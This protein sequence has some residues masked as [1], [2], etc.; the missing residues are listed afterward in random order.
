MAA[1]WPFA[2]CTQALEA[3]HI[4]HGHEMKEIRQQSRTIPWEEPLIWLLLSTHELVLSFFSIFYVDLDL[5][6]RAR[7]CSRD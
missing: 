4:F 5:T 3:N 2:A 7:K 1:T 6:I